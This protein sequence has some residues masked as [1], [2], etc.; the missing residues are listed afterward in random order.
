MFKLQEALIILLNCT[1]S[2]HLG[3]FLALFYTGDKLKLLPKYDKWAVIVVFFGQEF[4]AFTSW[5]ESDI[6][7]RYWQHFY[8]MG[9]DDRDLHLDNSTLVMAGTQSQN[10]W[11]RRSAFYSLQKSFI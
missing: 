11:H 2:S 6:H 10:M 5:L 8:F 3:I 4:M 7:F 1:N 9:Y